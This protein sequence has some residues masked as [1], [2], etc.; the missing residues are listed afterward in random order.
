MGYPDP[1]SY[2]A[3]AESL[4]IGDR[5]TLPG[6]IYYRDAHAYLAL[7]DVAVAPKLSTTEGSGKISNYMAMG[8][9]V[10]VFDT[11]VSREMLGPV[12]YYAQPGSAPDLAAQIGQAL[13]QPADAVARGA[14]G[15]AR[16]IADFSWEQGARQIEAIYRQVLQPERPASAP[17]EPSPAPST[18]LPDEA[19]SHQR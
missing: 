5:V 8:L 7:G 19:P 14:A 18:V 1:A 12:G 16:V 2:R 15:R 3:Y 17:Q 4:G 13:A 9:P 6:R 10:V 11:P